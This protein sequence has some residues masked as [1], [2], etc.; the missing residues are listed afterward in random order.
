MNDK[1][2]CTDLAGKMECFLAWIDGRE[3]DVGSA[4][5]EKDEN[6]FGSDVVLYKREGVGQGSSAAGG[7]V[8]KDGEGILGEARGLKHDLGRGAPEDDDSDLVAVPEAVREQAG[9]CALDQAHA[10]LGSVGAAGIDEQEITGAG[11]RLA[12]AFVQVR[13][14][15][16]ELT[17]FPDG[18]G[19]G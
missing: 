3:G 15:H 2:G 8:L 9:G 18:V 19:E 1:G 7:K 16:L 6:R 12:N 13:A 17:G 14:A 11:L 5:R 4:I 10:L